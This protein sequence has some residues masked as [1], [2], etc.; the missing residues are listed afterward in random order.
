MDADRIDDFQTHEFVGE[1][2]QSPGCV[3][4]RGLRAS[5][6]D[7]SGLAASVEFPGRARSDLGLVF[8]SRTE[9]AFDRTAADIGDGVGVD[10][11][12]ASDFGVG[13]CGAIV[14]LVG[15]EKDAGSGEPAGGGFT[16]TQH[17]FEFV[18][19]RNRERHSIDLFH[20]TCPK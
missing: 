11:E 13:P 8:Q 2:L 14:G 19:F 10:V 17:P 16:R 20:A 5:Q 1:Q 18:S 7:Q 15:L 6:F 4:Q 12:C 9:P 3:P